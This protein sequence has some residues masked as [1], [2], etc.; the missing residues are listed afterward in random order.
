PFRLNPTAA[1]TFFLKTANVLFQGGTIAV[2]LPWVHWFTIEPL[3]DA[4]NANTDAIAA[5]GYPA[6]IAW[7]LALIFTVSESA[8]LRKISLL[9]GLAGYYALHNHLNPLFAFALFFC[10][11]HSAPHYLKASE[12]LGTSATRPKKSFWVNTVCAWIM[13]LLAA[14]FFDTFADA[15]APLL[16]A[17][18]AILFALTLPHMIIVDILLPKHFLAWRITA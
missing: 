16:S 7:L 6:L 12:H 15:V 4:L 18:F 2:F 3:F 11:L 1:P 10:L 8:S 13:V 17:L 14:A 5:T 9:I